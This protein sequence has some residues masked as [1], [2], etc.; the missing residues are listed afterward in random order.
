MISGR[1][2]NKRQTFWLSLVI[3]LIPTSLSAGFGYGFDINYLAGKTTATVGNS[4]SSLN[5][6]G[7]LIS[8]FMRYAI[9]LGSLGKLSVGAYGGYGYATPNSLPSNLNYDVTTAFVYG[10]ELYL[11]F[12]LFSGF[13]PFA[14]VYA[15]RYHSEE[16]ASV[17]SASSSSVLTYSSNGMSYGALLGFAIPLNDVLSLFFQGGYSLTPK[18]TFS[19]DAIS[20][21]LSAAGITPGTTYEVESSSFR[22]GG[23]LMFEL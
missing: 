2:V 18:R 10:G 20:G 11:S 4:T 22:L 1:S 12:N 8:P 17:K 3:L 13:K 21:N 5:S 16:Q 14:R 9:N 7:Y 19:T 23:G 6:S 15:G